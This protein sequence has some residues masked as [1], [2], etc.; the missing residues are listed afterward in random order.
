MAA[1]L[2]DLTQ[3][4]QRTVGELT[5]RVQKNTCQFLVNQIEW[6]EKELTNIYRSAV[7]ASRELDEADDIADL[8]QRAEGVCDAVLKVFVSACGEYPECPA[9]LS[10][11]FEIKMAC[12][13]QE[14]FHRCA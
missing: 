11:L 1:L 6:A 12:H 10:G 5:E 3:S 2:D 13:E 7:E 14:E 4:G 8:W 9:Q